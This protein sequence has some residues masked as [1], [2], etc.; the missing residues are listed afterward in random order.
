M[1]HVV[2]SWYSGG[3]VLDPYLRTQSRQFSSACC[4]APS[5]STVT[6]KAS[7]VCNRQSVNIPKNSDLSSIGVERLR[8]IQFSRDWIPLIS[9]VLGGC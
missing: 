2:T 9:D 8:S 3:G 7:W 4:T 1:Y 5:C 6:C